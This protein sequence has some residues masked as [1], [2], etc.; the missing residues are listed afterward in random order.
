MK[1]AS[2]KQWKLIFILMINEEEGRKT[3]RRKASERNMYIVAE[4]E[5]KGFSPLLYGE[6]LSES[7]LLR[8]KRKEKKENTI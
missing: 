2:S 4:R 8:K 6:K 5:E 7:N 3:L 1:R